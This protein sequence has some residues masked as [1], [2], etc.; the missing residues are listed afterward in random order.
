MRNEKEAREAIKETLW[1][2]AIFAALM[3]IIFS[4]VMTLAITFAV[5][6]DFCR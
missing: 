1:Q 2:S 6:K 4:A 3:G 5:M